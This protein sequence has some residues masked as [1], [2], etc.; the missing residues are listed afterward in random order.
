MDIEHEQIDQADLKLLGIPENEASFL[1]TVRR[2]NWE[3]LQAALELPRLSQWAVEQIQSRLHD[4]EAGRDLPAL[5]A[6]LDSA[7]EA[8]AN[9]E[10]VARQF[11]DGVPYDRLRVVN[12]ARFYMQQSADAMLELGKRLIQLKENEPHGTFSDIVENE[13]N[14]APAVAR[15][16]MQASVK[17]LGNG[18]PGDPKR[19]ALSVLGKTKLYELMVLDDDELDALADGGTV[20]GLQQ[21]D[22]DR[23]TSRELRAALRNQ[24]QAADSRLTEAQESLETA[25]RVSQ[26]KQEQ[27]DRLQEELERERGAAKKA[28]PDERIARQRETCKTLADVLSVD[29][30]QLAAN[31]RPLLEAFPQQA[32]FA[33]GLVAQAI[34]ELRGIQDEHHL[35]VRP[36]GDNEVADLM[37]QALR[38]TGLTAEA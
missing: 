30:L 8:M 26:K 32:D 24:R 21:D 23:M 34:A 19:S 22:I 14:I 5:P 31:I 10:T 13:L 11:G 17:F 2:A 29:I 27:I 9:S 35:S 15:R 4:L 16:M 20:A 28:A 3:T 38:E 12:E 25:R 1:A 7:R 37:A 18:V 36:T 6:M 33:A